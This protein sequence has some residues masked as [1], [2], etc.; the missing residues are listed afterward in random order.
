MAIGLGSSVYIWDATNDT[1]H[2]LVELEGEG[3]YVSS[4]SW[5]GNGKFLAVGDSTAAVQLWDVQ[6]EKKLR[7]MTGGHT[8]RVGVLAWNKHTVARYAWWVGHV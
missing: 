1:S 5:S 3:H 8:G 7:T 4:V 2:S 6:R